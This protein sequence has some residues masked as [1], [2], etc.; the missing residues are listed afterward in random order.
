MA[1]RTSAEEVKC[2]KNAVA[3]SALTH[4]AEIV[5]FMYLGCIMEVY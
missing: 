4:A 3:A 2:P 5:A 1:K